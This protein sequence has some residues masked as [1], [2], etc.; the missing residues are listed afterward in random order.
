MFF[1]YLQTR[2]IVSG[3]TRGRGFRLVALSLGV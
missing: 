1:A 2:I 3:L